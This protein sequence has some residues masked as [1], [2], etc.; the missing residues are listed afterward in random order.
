ME[1]IT[2]MPPEFAGTA[3]VALVNAS[4]KTQ[5]RINRSGDKFVLVALVQSP[6]SPGT[7]N[8]LIDEYDS[9]EKAR[10]AAETD[11]GSGKRQ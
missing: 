8:Q 11:F 10:E 7:V 1:W 5:Y 2:E 4:E 6:G 3:T 9:E